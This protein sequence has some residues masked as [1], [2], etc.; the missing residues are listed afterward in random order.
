MNFIGTRGIGVPVRDFVAVPGR[1]V[2]GTVTGQPIV[3]GT[4]VLMRESSIELAALKATAQRW[5]AD[6][7]TPVFASV[8]GTVVAFAI[9]DTLRAN[10]AD[11]VARLKQQGLRVVM[12]SGD[13]KL[14]AEAIA[15]Q[16][17]IN[18]VIAEVLPDGKVDAIKTLQA[19]G[20]RVAMVGDGLND[21]PALAQADV[22]LAMASGTDIAIEAADVT[23]MR[24]DLEGVRQ[25]IV[26]AR[27]TMRT[28][29]ENLFWAFIYNVVGIPIA[30]GALYPAFGILLNPIIASAAMAFSSVSVVTNSF[31]LRRIRSYGR[32]GPGKAVGV[33]ADLISREPAP[34]A[35]H[36]GADS[37]P[38][39]DGGRRPLL[40]RHRDADRV[41][42]G[43]A[44][45]R[46][47]ATDAESP[48]ALC[49][50][51]D[52]SRSARSR[53]HVRRAP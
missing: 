44:S 31:G 1:G 14:T 49:H 25:A 20:R 23:L 2:K 19:Q 18:E 33:D 5:A 6:G 28:M 52:Q 26:L 7:K 35:A 11:V 53:N 3:V 24:S 8:A 38:A 13:R 9:A 21:A 41:G 30:A 32:P 51:R 17:G 39:E 29:K 27:K 50:Y 42:A 47:P 37:R 34:L 45:R 4:E 22:G 48:E 10:S 40:C 46:R 12:L 36:R 43:S 16:V 15:R